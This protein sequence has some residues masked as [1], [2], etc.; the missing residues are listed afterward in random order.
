MYYRDALGAVLVYDVTFK[1][2]F[3]R[4]SWLLMGRV[5]ELKGFG[6]KDIEI[7]IAGNKCDMTHQI[8]ITKAEADAYA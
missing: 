5:E 3:L 4:V 7:V 1:E 8:Q 2:S 6:S